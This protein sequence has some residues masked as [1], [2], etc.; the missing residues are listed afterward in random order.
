MPIHDIIMA[1]AGNAGSVGGLQFVGGFGASVTAA[2]SISVSLTSL[3]GGLASSPSAGDIVLACVSFVNS[4]DINI[5][6]TTSGYTELADLYVNGTRDTNFAVFYKV[7]ST[8]ETSVAFDGTGTT[9][10]NVS[11]IVHVWRGVNQTNPLDATSTTSTNTSSCI[12]DGA[13]I[14]TVTDKAVVVCFGASSG[15][16]TQ[17]TIPNLTVP[18][19]GS[20]FVEAY[21][22]SGDNENTQA[23]FSR[24][25]TPAGAYNPPAFGITGA[26][27]NT[28][29]TAAALTLALRPA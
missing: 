16:G 11:V 2:A 3:S 29:F 18:S 6:C 9:Q 7:L 21:D 13:S 17:P 4:T 19:G 1:A 14:T 15:G 20:N 8:A 23:V 25:I 22:S 27:D 24:V 5:G 12:P 10:S 26:S 28:N